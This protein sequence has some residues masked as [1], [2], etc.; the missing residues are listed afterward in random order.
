MCIQREIYLSN[1]SSNL[2]SVVGCTYPYFFQELEIILAT[3]L[4]LTLI[5][6]KIPL[7]PSE[8]R[9]VTFLHLKTRTL[10][11]TETYC[12]P[13]RGSRILVTLLAAQAMATL[14]GTHEL[15]YSNSG[16]QAF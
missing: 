6:G 9:G 12:A 14:K 5:G 7:E 10:K 8:K 15:D 11:C 13:H 1:L 3:Q 4:L 2:N 16:P